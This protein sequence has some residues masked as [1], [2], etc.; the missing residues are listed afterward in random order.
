MSLKKDGKQEKMK[1]KTTKKHEKQHFKFDNRTQKI[2][3]IMNELIKS[4]Y[5]DERRHEKRKATKTELRPTLSSCCL[6]YPVRLI[7]KRKGK[8][9]R[10]REEEEKSRKEWKN[11]DNGKPK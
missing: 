4:K 8:N 3:S 5:D 2:G 11:N 6:V 7:L 1:M 9:H 10:E